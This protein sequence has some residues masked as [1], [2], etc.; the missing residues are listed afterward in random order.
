MI[1][2]SETFASP[3]GEGQ[4]AGM[5]SVWLRFFGCNLNCSGFGQVHPTKPETYDLPYEDFDESSIT[6]LKQLPVWSKGCDSSYSWASKFRHLAKSGSAKEIA[7]ILVDLNKNE[8]NP[9]G[10]FIHPKTGMYIQLV[11]TGGEPMLF[12]GGMLDILMALEEMNNPP[13]MV[14]VET[15]GTQELRHELLDYVSRY[16]KWHWSISPKLFTVS[17]EKDV[18]NYQNIF[19]YNNKCYAETSLKFVSN[20]T[21]ESWAELDEHLEKIRLVYDK[22]NQITPD[23]WIMP[24]GATTESQKLPSVGEIAREANRRGFMVATRSHIQ[25]FG[26]QIGT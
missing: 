11:F 25:L 3:Q 10:L 22:N 5:P 21:P 1:R 12:Q 18:V 4:Y 6:D 9:K 20:G 2:Y 7:Q 16:N 26:N 14:T 8:H 13:P 23:V 19:T 24:V 15:N 17:G